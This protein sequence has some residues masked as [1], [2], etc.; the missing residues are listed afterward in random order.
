MFGAKSAEDDAGRYSAV[1]TVDACAP[2]HAPWLNERSSTPPVS[3]ARQSLIFAACDAGATA[4][5]VISVRDATTAISFNDFFKAP[6]ELALLKKGLMCGKPYRFGYRLQ[7]FQGYGAITNSQPQL[8]SFVSDE[9]SFAK[10]VRPL[11]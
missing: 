11:P 2:A 10:Y 6:P 5:P 1:D 3:S 7:V 9:R 4:T 8:Q